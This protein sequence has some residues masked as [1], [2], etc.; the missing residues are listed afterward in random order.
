MSSTQCAQRARDTVLAGTAFVVGGDDGA[1]DRRRLLEAAVADLDRLPDVERRQ[2]LRRMVLLPAVVAW[3]L[4]GDR[5][6]A[7]LAVA[8]AVDIDPGGD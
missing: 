3:E 2:V 8:A 4:T 5:A 6:D 1:A 7:W